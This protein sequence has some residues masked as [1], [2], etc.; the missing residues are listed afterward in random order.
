MIVPIFIIAVGTAYSLH[1]ISEYAVSARRAASDPD[2][3]AA[4][5][6]H[7][8]LPCA[9]AVFTTLFGPGEDPRKSVS[10]PA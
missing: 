7:T 9:L 1:T 10:Q 6:A 3:L 5:Y 8:A 2:A 4:T